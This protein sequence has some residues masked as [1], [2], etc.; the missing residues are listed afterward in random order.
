MNK[1]TE[2]DDLKAVV[3]GFYDLQKLRI[4][5]GNRIVASIYAKMGVEPG[6]KLEDGLSVKEQKLLKQIEAEYRRVTDGVIVKRGTLREHFKNPDVLISNQS[7]FAL[8]ESYVTLMMME[9]SQE[10]HIKKVLEGF[11]IWT[12]FLLGIKGVGPLMGGVIISKLDPHKA[13]YPSSFW[14]FCGLDVGPDGK[15]RG[16]YTA[17]LEER[18]Y[19]AKDGTTKIKMGLTYDPWIKS[20]LIGVLAASFLKC[21]SPKYSQLYAD[22]KNRLKNRDPEDR[23]VIH[24]KRALRYI[25]KIFLLDLWEVWR[26][27]EGLPVPG[28]YHVV[29]LGLSKHAA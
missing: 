8:A 27:Q 24:H 10:R 18:E 2:R 23:P 6:E 15:G 20:K 16:K 3:Q 28:P 14:K 26:A 7:E 4:S 21:K 19:T 22:Y 5:T 9:T 11:P 1:L 29:K 25:I 17:H 13:K 12:D